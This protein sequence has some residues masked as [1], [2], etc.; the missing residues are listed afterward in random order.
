MDVVFAST[1]RLNN[2]FRLS[3]PLKSVATIDINHT[4]WFDSSGDPQRTK[5]DCPVK[6]LSCKQ[7]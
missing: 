6:K 5:L 4:H 2:T 7:R 1:L 3:R